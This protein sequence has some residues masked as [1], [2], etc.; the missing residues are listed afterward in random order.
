VT[1]RRTD[2][3]EDADP[4]L[5]SMRTV[6]REMRDEDPPVRG[7]DAL[8]AAARAQ[9][10]EHA[11]VPWWRRGF[12][13]LARPP[14]LALATA[15][16]VLGGVVLVERASRDHAPPQ[17]T[18]QM[19]TEAPKTPALET[20][21]GDALEERS[22]APAG[23]TAPPTEAPAAR[24]EEPA[25]TPAMPSRRRAPVPAPDPAPVESASEGPDSGEGDVR[26]SRGGSPATL[27]DQLVRQ[28]EGAAA[29]GDCVTVRAATARLRKLDPKLYASRVGGRA[30]VVRC[31]G[32]P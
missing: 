4:V 13:A 5:R 25:P 6:W 20:G 26:V 31:L 17:V 18:K 27:R 14:V 12:A 7:I 10:A 15:V 3:T 8:L 19:H 23:A 22:A 9:V 16:V 11:P 21:R 29:R 30:A 1:E 32:T 2:D 24:P 28:I